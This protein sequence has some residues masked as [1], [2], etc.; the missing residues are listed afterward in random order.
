MVDRFL[1]RHGEF[2]R[3]AS[4]ALPPPVGALLTPEGALRTYPFRDGLEAFF[5]AV[6]V[7]SADSQ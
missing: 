4:P 5:A 6:L 7:K 2:A 3:G 1:S